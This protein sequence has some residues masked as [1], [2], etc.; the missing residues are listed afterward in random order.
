MILTVHFKIGIEIN[1]KRLNRVKE[2]EDL[3][4]FTFDMLLT[5]LILSGCEYS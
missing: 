5:A 1:L 2:P 3:S 4:T